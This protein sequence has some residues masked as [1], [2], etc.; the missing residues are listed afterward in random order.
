MEIT[1]MKR[2][3]LV[4]ILGIVSISSVIGG[5]TFASS[6]GLSQTVWMIVGFIAAIPGIVIGQNDVRRKSIMKE[7]IIYVGMILCFI[8]LG[9][10]IL[11]F[12]LWAACTC[13]DSSLF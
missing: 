12:L 8:A 7:G 11:F 1:R 4:L 6:G 2:P 9:G 10:V 5:W 13:T 3:L